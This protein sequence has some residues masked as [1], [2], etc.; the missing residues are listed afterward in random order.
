LLR[1][2]LAQNDRIHQCVSYG[3]PF[4]GQ[5]HRHPGRLSDRLGLTQDDIEHCAVDCAVGREEQ[6]RADQFGWLAEAVDT[7]LT[8][9]VTRWVPAQVVMNHGVEQL[10]QIDALGQ[11]IRSHQEPLLGVDQGF[12]ARDAVVGRQRAGYRLSAALETPCEGLLRRNRR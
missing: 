8:L 6:Y 10:L 7:T 4:V 12:D 5:G 9:L 11:A 1:P 3:A 2:A